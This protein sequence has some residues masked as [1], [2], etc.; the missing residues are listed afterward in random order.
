MMGQLVALVDKS[1]D[2]SDDL[3]GRIKAANKRRNHLVH[4]YWREKAFVFSTPE[5]R[6]KMIE[7]LSGDA[8]TFDR[9]AADVYEATKPI[10]ARLGT[11]DEVLDEHVAQQMTN[12]RAG[13]PL[14]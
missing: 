13:L 8:D 7:E 10:R 14:K 12:I 2:F 1:A 9:L 11:K 6:A 5:G 3:K 4:S